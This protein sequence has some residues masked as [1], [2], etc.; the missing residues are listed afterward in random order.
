MT[1]QTAGVT[2]YCFEENGVGKIAVCK[3]QASRA[4]DDKSRK[5]SRKTVS[6]GI[7]CLR[8]NCLRY[9]DPVL[10]VG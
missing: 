8:R 4:L 7:E 3:I 2:V 10:P 9:V 1:T 6:S 5:D